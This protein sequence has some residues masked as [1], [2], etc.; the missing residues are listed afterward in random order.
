M[1]DIGLWMFSNRL[2][3]NVEKMQ[4]TCFDTKYQFAKVDNS[5]FVANGSVD[6]LLPVVTYLGVTIDQKL[7][8][9][10]HI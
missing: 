1:D 6:D 3:L 8:F 9:A 2:K 5:A 7:T 4:F 10:D